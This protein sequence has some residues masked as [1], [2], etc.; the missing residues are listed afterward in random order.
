MFGNMKSLR[1]KLM[2]VVS[3]LLLAPMLI[4]VVIAQYQS[5]TVIREKSLALS[6]RLV[7][8]GTE[9]LDLLLD[10]MNDLYRSLYL[11]DNFL[12]YLRLEASAGGAF[13]PVSGY[14]ALLGSDFLTG[15][16]TQSDVYSMIYID[17]RGQVVFATRNEAGSFSEPYSC[18]LPESYLRLWEE[19]NDWTEGLRLLPTERHMPSTRLKLGQP[20]QVYAVARRILNVEN[21]FQPLGVLFITLD[22]SSLERMAHLIQPDD[23]SSVLFALPDSSVLYDSTGKYAAGRLPSSLANADGDA[24]E[25]DGVA[26]RLAFSAASR[27]MCRVYLLTPEEV[28]SAGAMRVSRSILLAALAAVAIVAVV[29]AVSSRAISR[30][31]ERLAA[32]M[33]E[34]NLD[35]LDR[36]I[37]ISGSDEIARLGRSFNLLMDKLDVSLQN[38]YR[39]ALQEKEANIRALQAQMNPHFLYN[40]LQS[41]SSLAAIHH[42]PQIVS[43]TSSLGEVLRYT[44]RNGDALVPLRQ[45]VTHTLH[46]LSIQKIRLGTRLQYELNVPERL[47]DYLTP[48]VSLQPMVEN[49]ILHGLEG[50]EETGR[51]LI[52]AWEEEE[53]LIVEVS[54]DGVG[55]SSE[56]MEALQKEL[57]DPALWKNQKG[58]G[59][60]LKNLQSRLKLLYGGKAWVEVESVSGVGTCA[61]MVLPPVREENV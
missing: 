40:V 21:A 53:R 51:L 60:G 52:C 13:V 12:Q 15:L 18:G 46:Y 42:A 34:T 8:A 20:P 27:D 28:Y 30:P 37:E 39:M 17:A 29:T 59:L 48:R 55:I 45:E 16:S 35:N 54:D 11:S 33:D 61:R 47:L 2:L 36:R 7:Q 26:Y 10:G 41:I 31:V 44:I 14:A 22:L 50:R 58:G 49:A 5:Q 43:L 38:E 9:R 56:R 19:K 24:V 3:A 25:L 1:K 23:G 57:N 6:T 4:V 32:F